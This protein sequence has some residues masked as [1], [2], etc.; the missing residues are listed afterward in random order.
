VEPQGVVLSLTRQSDIGYHLAE[1]EAW[2]T[3][4]DSGRRTTPLAYAAFELRLE[5]ERVAFELLT[6]IRGDQLV[7][8]DFRGLRFGRMERRIYELEG[9]QRVLDR[10]VAFHNILLNAVQMPLRLHSV[11][12]GKLRKGWETCSALCHITFS[13][14]AAIPDSDV[15]EVA[16]REVTEVQRFVRSVV[17][18]GITWPRVAHSGF[19]ELQSKYVREE[20]GDSDVL[21]WVKTHGL[22]GKTEHPDGRMEAVGIAIPPGPKQVTASPAPTAPE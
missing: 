13:L 19:A 6:R 16:F 4:S 3:A 5:T 18:A 17:D 11:N 1:A 10:K 22:W 20:I 15:G 8:E 14:A 7:P 9:H 21:E 12:L 2:L